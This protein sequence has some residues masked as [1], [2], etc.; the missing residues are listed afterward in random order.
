[1]D[2]F[3]FFFLMYS[4]QNERRGFPSLYS[5]WGVLVDFH[6]VIYNYLLSKENIISQLAPLQ[7]IPVRR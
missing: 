3:M 5:C 1:M 6:A 2:C 4:E 7:E